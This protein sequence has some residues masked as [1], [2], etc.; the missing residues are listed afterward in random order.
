MSI[1]TEFRAKA[2][3]SRQTI[4]SKEIEDVDRKIAALDVIRSDLKRS[5]LGLREEE[6]ELAD[7][8]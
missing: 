8:R 6:L 7:E 5:L 2:D 4:I 1:N 3:S